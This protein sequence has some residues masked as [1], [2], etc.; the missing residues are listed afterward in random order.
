MRGREPIMPQ[1]RRRIPPQFSWI[2]HRLS[3]LSAVLSG[4]KRD[5][6]RCPPGGMRRL[7]IVFVVP[8]LARRLRPEMP[9]RIAWLIEQHADRSGCRGVDI[10]RSP[11]S[12]NNPRLD[13][14]RNHRLGEGNRKM[15]SDRAWVMAR[16]LA[17]PRC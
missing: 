11:A 3:V 2:D 8:Y 10:P 15:K 17:E 7:A 1:R 6:R 9:E 12:S 14:S 16:K 13:A 4:V 5:V